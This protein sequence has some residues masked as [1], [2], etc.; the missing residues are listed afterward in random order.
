MK[1]LHKNDYFITKAYQPILLLDTIR[2]TLESILAK[3]TS[4][5][6]E[7]YSLLLK[8]DFG[9]CRSTSTE[10]AV[11]Y[12]IEK[13]YYE[14]NQ[15]KDRSSIM[16]NVTE[17]FDQVFHEK[18]FHNFRKQSMD[19]KIADWISSFITNRSTIVVSNEFV[20]GNIYIS[21]VTPQWLSLSLILYLFHNANLI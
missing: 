7:L 14:W 3:K 5:F 21:S 19:F 2:K 6:T 11:Y 13:I 10:N 17:A 1:K 20:S 8:T 12:L 18:L 4:P 9:S 16:L 15:G